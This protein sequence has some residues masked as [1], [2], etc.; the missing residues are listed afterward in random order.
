MQIDQNSVVSLNYKLSNDAGDVI[1]ECTDGSFTYLQGANN[2]IPGLESALTGKSKGEKLDVTIPPKDA[3]GER[4]DNSTQV[5]PR[6]MFPEDVTID[7]GMQFAA[8]GPDGQAMVV[9]TK[10]S[11]DHV[12]VDGNHPLAG[13]QLNFSVE[14]IEVRE[15]TAEEKEHGHV[16]GPDGHDHG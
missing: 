1:D 11:D 13:V 3:Y 5:V 10:V 12:T 8:Q 16:H 6:T 4:D 9:V 7:V 2:I 14:I 15:A